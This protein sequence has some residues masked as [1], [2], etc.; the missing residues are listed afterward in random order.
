MALLKSIVR[1]FL[2]VSTRLSSTF[3]IRRGICAVVLQPALYYHSGD[4]QN[5]KLGMVVRRRIA[6]VEDDDL[7][8]SNYCQLLR[9]DGF[10]VT[11][12][13]NKLDA[14]AAFR[15][16]L[17]DL[18]LLDVTHEGERDAG[19]QI[20]SE[21]RQISSEVPIIF[22]TSHSGEIDRISGLRLGADD[23]ITKDA[24]MEYVIIR[25]E[26]LFRRLDAIRSSYSQQ[27]PAEAVTGT[28]TDIELDEVYS[29]ISWKGSKIDLP[30]TL[31]WIV[32]ELCSNPGKVKSHRE[33]MKASNIVVEPNTI[34]AHVKSIRGAFVRADSNFQCIKT[35]RGRGYRWVP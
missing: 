1:A 27:G 4:S 22:L 19:Y 33:L 28:D 7:T 34:A 3:I 9:D 11:A 29:T 21:L 13:S 14:L 5:M 32:Q 16:E 18:A 20:C 6:Y 31:F 24:S 25:I 10:D 17:P 15:E 23:Y 30:L 26:A 8:R 12:Y 35:E 2:P